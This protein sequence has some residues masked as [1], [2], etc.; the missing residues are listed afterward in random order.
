MTIEEKEQF[1]ALYWGQEA[2]CDPSIPNRKFVINCN[3][4]QCINVDG[5]LELKSL[6]NISDG[7]AIEVAKIVKRKYL[8]HYKEGQITFKVVR[9]KHSVKVTF[10]YNN[11]FQIEV[12]INENSI[13]NRD[14]RE[15]GNGEY[16][17]T[18]NQKEVFDYL[19][20]KSYSI[21][22]RQYSVEDLVKKGIIKLI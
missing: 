20:S 5:Y 3:T 6:S 4:I 13:N 7:D 2:Y 16:F 19:I 8:S 21:S 22:F 14:S 11:T 15:Y 10:Y 12:E 9:E 1:F 17:Y 18:H